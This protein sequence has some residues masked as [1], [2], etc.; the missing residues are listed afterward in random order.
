[1]ALCLSVS[2]SYIWS[3]SLGF[4]PID[5]FFTFPSNSKLSLPAFGLI[6]VRRIFFLANGLCLPSLRFSEADKNWVR[7]SLPDAVVQGSD[8]ECPHEDGADGSTGSLLARSWFYSVATSSLGSAFF[9][10]SLTKP[11]APK[12]RYYFPTGEVSDRRHLLSYRPISVK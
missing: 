5:A 3:S 9:R 10:G 4:L 2:F 8:S 12:A 7:T 1:M 11:A 6:S